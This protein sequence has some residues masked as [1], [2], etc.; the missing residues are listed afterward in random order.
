MP[1]Q[2]SRS[3]VRELLRTSNAREI[4]EAPSAPQPAPVPAE[5]I[6][7]VEALRTCARTHGW[8][9]GRDSFDAGH[10][11]DG[12]ECLLAREVVLLV[13]VL[14]NG[15][16]GSAALGVWLR[17]FAQAGAE[18]AIWHPWNRREMEARLSRPW[19]PRS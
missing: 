19:T 8:K 3:A 17:H 14:P 9:A 7:F 10:P 6:T 15:A 16:Q 5:V 4:D 13:H 12:V 18:V 2:M 11:E 1:I